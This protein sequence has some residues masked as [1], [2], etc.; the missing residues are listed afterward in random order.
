M[1]TTITE[2]NPRVWIGCLACYS[3]GDL[4]GGWA[5][6]I[7]VDEFI[8]NFNSNLFP[9]RFNTPAVQPAPTAHLVEC[10]EEWW[11]M[12]HDNF[13]GFLNGECSPMKAQQVA[14][15]MTAVVAHGDDLEAV[16]AWAKIRDEP[17]IEWDKPTQDE[18]QSALIGKYDSFTDF[19]QEMLTEQLEREEIPE[20]I[21]DLID[22][23]AYARSFIGVYSTVDVLGIYGEVSAVYIFNR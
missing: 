1:C 23:A 9:D 19:A 16:S 6:A 17:V 7:E 3:A 22:V 12:D 21:H 20:W 4:V 15:L 2:A 14:E 18:F 13:G 10:H 5:D 8:E 11:V